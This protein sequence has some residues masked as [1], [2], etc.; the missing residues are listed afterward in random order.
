M[1]FLII[2][3]MRPTAVDVWAKLLP[4]HFKYLDELERKNVVEVSYHLIGHQG[5]VL[6]VKAD[7]DEEL[8]GI[9][10]E[11]P[12]FFYCEREVYPLTTRAVHKRRLEAIVGRARTR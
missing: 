7:S 3:K 2:A 6:I 10:G 4:A 8:A 12:L 9:V 1:K 11:D 5:D